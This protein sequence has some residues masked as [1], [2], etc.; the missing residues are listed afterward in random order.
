MLADSDSNVKWAVARACELSAVAEVEVR[1]VRSAV[2]PSAAQVREAV[3][4]RWVVPPVVDWTDVAAEAATGGP[5]VVVLAARGPLVEFL[6]RAVWPDA[7]ARPVVV[8]GIPGVWC[9]PTVRGVDFR[10]GCD[11]WVVHSHRERELLQLMVGQDVAVGLASLARGAAFAER[12]GDGAVIF[13]P[14]ALVPRTVEQRLHLL[15]RWCDAARAHPEVPFIIKVRGVKGEAQTHAEFAAYDDLVERLPGG[16]QRGLP[17]NVTFERGPLQDFLGGARGLVTVS[18]T[19]ALE[20]MG[21]GV[22]CLVLDDFGVGPELLNEVFVGSGC[23]GS[24]GRL[25]ELEFALP[26]AGWRARHYFHAP[27]EDDWVEAVAERVECGGPRPALLAG[28]L[29]VRG[30]VRR[31]RVRRQALGQADAWGW[32]VLSAVVVTPAVGVKRRGF[33]VFSR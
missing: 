28:P 26:S 8:V 1:V 17:A 14:Q 2:T 27:D 12:R 23:M 7:A 25:Q 19:A 20:A 29:G 32:R 13:A 33:P 22:P 5:D 30:V 9:P 15:E 10:W 11:V 4:D 6:L 21:A 24:L 16:L 31:M 18:S 3:A